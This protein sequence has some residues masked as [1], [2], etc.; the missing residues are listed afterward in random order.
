MEGLDLAVAVL[1]SV[2]VSFQGF[3][4]T[5]LLAR[6]V[7]RRLPALGLLAGALLAQVI[8]TFIVD[9]QLGSHVMKIFS[10]MNYPVL[11]VLFTR[12]AF[13]NQTK[14]PF[15]FILLLVV[16]L[17]VVHAVEYAIVGLSFPPLSPVEPGSALQYWFH[18]ALVAVMH[19]VSLGWL[20][21]AVG[22]AR[23]SMAGRPVDPWVRSRNKWL[24]ASTVAYA[25]APAFWLLL[26]TD[27]TG[28]TS[29]FGIILGVMTL[30]ITMFHAIAN[31]LY[32]TMPGWFAGWLDRARSGSSHEWARSGE[33]SDQTKV[34]TKREILAVVDYL[35]EKLAP[36]IDKPP[37]AAKGLL[38]MAIQK[39]LGEKAQ[40]ALAFNDVSRVIDGSLRAML[41]SLD[42]P[43]VE[44]IVRDM[45]AILVE[46]Q[47]LLAMMSL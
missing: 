44:D 26:P 35:G 40:Y 9:L 23:R 17:R 13:F 33:I 10:M 47:A 29:P 3:T 7:R 6:A 25:F 41:A 14:S 12:H 2:Y 42:I 38:F 5:Y 36:R 11:Y 19:V 46:D 39:Q 18:M 31:L 30:F 21:R 8:D 1:Y 22:V 24:F 37:S 43:R 16:S 45:K 34:L 28:Y 15:K 32:W 20:A 27:G 4:G